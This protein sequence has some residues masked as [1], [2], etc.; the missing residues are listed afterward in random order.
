MSAKHNDIVKNETEDTISVQI[1]IPATSPEYVFVMI[2]KTDVNLRFFV[3]V[4]IQNEEIKADRFQL[5]KTKELIKDKTWI[6]MISKLDMLFSC[7]K[8]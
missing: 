7:S 5:L 8:V 3:E 1:L 6:K 4:D 2:H